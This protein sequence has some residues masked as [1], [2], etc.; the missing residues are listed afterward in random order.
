MAYPD[1]YYACEHGLNATIKRIDD[2]ADANTARRAILPALMM[3]DDSDED[4]VCLYVSPW[5]PYVQKVRDN[6]GSG[7]DGDDDVK[8]KQ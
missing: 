8:E 4:E 3:A 6:G 7:D 1:E 2:T 5:G